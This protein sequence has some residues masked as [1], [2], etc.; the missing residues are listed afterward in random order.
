MT[1]TDLVLNAMT[2]LFVKRDTGA[3]ERYCSS[4]Y[5]QHNPEIPDGREHLAAWA[6]TLPPSFRYEPGVVVASGD[7]VMIHGRYSGFGDKPL[8]AVDIFRIEGGKLAEHW[9]VV[10]LEVPAAATRSGRPMFTGG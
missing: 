7:H 1:N 9:D 2:E 8:L 3:V 10:Q 4:A 5:R 6:S